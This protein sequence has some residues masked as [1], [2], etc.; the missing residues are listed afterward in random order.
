MILINFSHPLSQANIQQIKNLTQKNVDC[1]LNH[2][3]DF[4]PKQSFSSQA[5]KL[6]DQVELTPLQWQTEPILVILPALNFIAA[7]ILA[8]LDGRMGYLP[9]IIRLREVEGI[10]PRCWEIAE[11]I[12]LHEIRSRARRKRIG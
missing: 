2:L 9:T 3:A 1:T 4:D 5:V 10:L 6:A 7:A 12:D 11:I 8:E